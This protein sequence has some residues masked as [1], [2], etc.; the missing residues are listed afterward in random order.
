MNNYF[1]NIATAAVAATGVVS[2]LQ[3]VPVNMVPYASL[4]GTGL[5]DFEDLTHVGGAGQNFD[6]IFES[7][8]TDFAERFV[9]QTLSYSGNFDVLTQTPSGLLKLQ[10]GAPGQNLDLLDYTPGGNVLTGLGIRGFPDYDAIGEGAF[11]ML[12]DYDQSEFG[13]RVVG[14][15]AG[16]A[17]IDFYRRN[18]TLID[19]VGMTNLGDGYYGFSREAGITDIA[20]VSI[21]NLDGGGVGFD[22]IKHSRQGVTGHPTPDAGSTLALLSFGIA[23]LASLRR[24]K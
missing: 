1:K 6:S 3:A 14:G 19:S 21:Y 9:G 5:I 8:G 4:T 23:A 7:A 15:N 16:T 22:D 24:G 2:S 10:V 12:F 11:S 17:T 20:G 13:F 18:G